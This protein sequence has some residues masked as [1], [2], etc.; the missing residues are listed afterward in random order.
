MKCDLDI[1]I[2]KEKIKNG[3][4]YEK[5]GKYFKCGHNK[6]Y[7][8]CNKLNIKKN[9]N[10]LINKKFGLFTVIEYFGKKGDHKTWLC[11][12]ECGN[13]K[14]MT[15]NEI[16]TKI[17][18][19]KISS[20]GCHKSNIEYQKSINQ[21][22]GY[23]KITG[24]W[25]SKCKWGA[26]VRNLEFSISKEDIWNQYIK[27]NK[28]CALTGQLV[29]FKTSRK[30]KNDTA[31]LDRK[32]ATKGYTI[33]NIQIVHKDINLTRLDYTIDEYKN[34]CTKVHNYSNNNEQLDY[35]I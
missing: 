7:Y 1:Q 5:I 11:K 25:F 6:I 12:C 34:I 4:S 21:W 26:S 32:D 29:I 15:T 2:L 17:K 31:S 28:K 20:C 19:F 16:N 30:D 23:E 9:K 27:Q 14:I 8:W 35:C 22:Q 33:D 10:S 24:S 13:S 18:K 3:E